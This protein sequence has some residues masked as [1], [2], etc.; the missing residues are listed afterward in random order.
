MLKTFQA[1]LTNKWRP[2]METPF[3]LAQ[4]YFITFNNVHGRVV[5]QHLLDNTYCV[6]APDDS[7][8]AALAAHNGRRALINEILVNIDAGEHP[9]KYYPRVQKEVESN[10]P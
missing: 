3:E 6:V 1:W 9:D 10:G 5:L 2:P 4:A 8:L 7:S